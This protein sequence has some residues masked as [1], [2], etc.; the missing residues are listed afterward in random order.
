MIINHG[1]NENRTKSRHRKYMLILDVDKKQTTNTAF[2]STLL[3]NV[4]N[5]V[6]RAQ[7]VNANDEKM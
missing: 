3:Y 6:S 1:W 2:R 7:S 4:P 5:S